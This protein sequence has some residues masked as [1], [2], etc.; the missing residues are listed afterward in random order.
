MPWIL[1]PIRPWLWWPL[2]E[3]VSPCRVLP[4]FSQLQSQMPAHLCI[5]PAWLLPACCNP[6]LGCPG[7]TPL[8]AAVQSH[9]A[10]CSNCCLHTRQVYSSLSPP[11]S[12]FF[13]QFP[14][15]QQEMVRSHRE[16]TGTWPSPR[17]PG[18]KI[19]LHPP[20]A[21]L[22][23]V[24]SKQMAEQAFPDNRNMFSHISQLSRSPDQVEISQQSPYGSTSPHFAPR[25]HCLLRVLESF[26]TRGHQAA[27]RGTLGLY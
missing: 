1:T 12:S 16:R 2:P 19:R 24:H 11:G 9:T 14:K 7:L 27:N 13:T 17:R 8:P 10:P 5:P 21:P 20:H 15:T 3:S 18:C 23:P 4:D 25:I 6:R 22:L 26:I